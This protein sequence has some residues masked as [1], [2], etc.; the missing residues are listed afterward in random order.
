MT[1]TIAIMAAGKGTRMR[2]ITDKVPKP[3]IEING[4]P[5]LHYLLTNIKKAGYTDII[6]IVGYLKEKIE[7]YLFDKALDVRVIEQ[8][9]IKGSGSA[10]K[11]LK[12][13]INGDFVVVNGDNLFSPEDL[14]LLRK[15]DGKFCMLAK[16][17]KN[18]EKYGVLVVNEDKLSRIVEKPKHFL[19]DL[20][21][22]GA[23]HFTPKIFDFLDK[24]RVSERGEYEIVDAL[25]LAA[26]ENKVKV[27]K[28]KDYWLDLGCP[29]DIEKIERFLNDKSNNI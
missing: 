21:N 4:R 20:I 5:F 2:P 1:K 16:K 12:E 10:I 24:V 13:C 27:L 3:M 23:Y 9:K 17:V 8:K 7:K 6:V 22:V 11:L 28:L 26:K 25:T 14:S 18:P 19:G 29:E 15:K